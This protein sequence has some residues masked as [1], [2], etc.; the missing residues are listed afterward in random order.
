[1]KHTKWIG[2]GLMAAA[3]V[4]L[5]AC[6]SSSE[7]S[8]AQ[9]SGDTAS[10]QA[11]TS[12]N[13]ALDKQE[14]IDNS[15]RHD[16]LTLQAKTNASLS[17]FGT[18]L[19]LQSLYEVYE[20]LYTMDAGGERYAVLADASRG[21][22]GGYDHE[23][24][25]GVYDFYI[26][27]YI[28]DHNGN[29]ITASD[30]AFSFVYQ[31]NNAETSGW[32]TFVSAEAVDDTTCRF[33][34][35]RDLT[36]LGEFDNIFCRQFIVSEASFDEDGNAF[37]NAMCGTGPYEFVSYTSGSTIVLKANEN[38]WQTDESLIRQESM[39][40]VENLV[41]SFV[42]EETQM[43]IGLETGTI[44]VAQVSASSLDDF[45]DG[46]KYADQFQ[47]YSFLD[48]LNVFMM[49]NCDPVS[50][51]SD[52]NLRLAIY[53]AIDNYGLATALGQGYEA[54]VMM[55]SSY[56]SDY[57]MVDWASLENY[58][59]K[60]T[61]DPEAVSAYLADS[62]YS[63]Q[64]LTILANNTLSKEVEIVVN[65][66]S[67]VGINAEPKLADISTYNALAADA[68]AW[69]ITINTM[70]GDFIATVWQHG[71]DVGNTAS[72]LAANF[73]DDP[74]WQELLEACYGSEESHTSEALL[75]WWQHAV[76][77]GYCMGLY[78]NYDYYVIPTY[79]ATFCMGDKQFALPGGFTF[80][81]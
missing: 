74:E 63:G 38:Y 24:G 22:Y 56:Y 36:G 54:A 73:V 70:A 25:T 14:N 34:F 45:Q 13:D 50:P 35:S 44:D 41:Y 28:Y 64:T 76:D 29:H 31:Y 20:M 47:I 57:D 17:P 60:A 19:D 3:C 11:V 9:P 30:V 77:N 21:E 66:L 5:A 62:S 18:K 12:N 1:M 27:D 55:G 40:N 80:N 37:A 39:Q 26:Y 15:V 71:F 51:T 49:C 75:A 16:S 42:D 4:S 67:A 72:G 46:G 65:M 6:G 32:D 10:T 33:T 2:I 7:S 59:T 69:D 53:N 61:V 23:D 48:K 43:V 8:S 52:V 58:N 81:E 79:V 78:N 68:S